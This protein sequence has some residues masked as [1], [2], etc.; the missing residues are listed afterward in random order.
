MAGQKT[1]KS[2]QRYYDEYKQN[3]TRDKNKITKLLKYL[4]I[5]PNNMVAIKRLQELQSLINK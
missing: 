3:R 1:S 5:H 4:K 2:K